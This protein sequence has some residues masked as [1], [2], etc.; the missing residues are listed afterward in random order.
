M[1]LPIAPPI[2]P[3]QFD[4]VGG[5]NNTT[6]GPAT[7][8][9]SHTATAGAYVVGFLVTYEFPL[10]PLKYGTSLMTLLGYVTE[11][12]TPSTYATIWMYGLA[13]APGGA[14]TVTAS[15]Q[16]AFATGNTVSY[17]NTFSVGQPVTVFGS[18]T[19]PSQTLTCPVGAILV[20]AFAA[21]AT[22]S[23]YSG[24]TSRYSGSSGGVD[25]LI[26]QDTTSSS[27]TFTGT[28][29]TSDPWAGIGAVL[30]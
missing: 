13:N 18:S 16:T 10:A 14:Q 19:T 15:P 1:L 3:P 28:L 7:F 8:T 23:V 4:A 24:G 30:S 17:I 11:N 9:W 29:T 12:N 25:V 5:G 2:P 6:S 22:F 26:I 27:A 20:Q 21:Q